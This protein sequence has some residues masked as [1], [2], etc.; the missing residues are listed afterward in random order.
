V[1][2]P[3]PDAPDAGD[4]VLRADLV[5]VVLHRID[6]PLREPFVAAHGTE[7]E[8]RV[9]L[10]EAI[11]GDGVAGWGE[12][13]A[14]TRPTYT[15]EYTDGAFREL[16]DRLVPAVLAGRPAGPDGAPMAWTGV[17]TALTDLRLRSLGRSLARAIGGR[18]TD[19][20][21]TAVIG[22]RGDADDL[23]AVV[24]ARV[25]EG[26]GS[27]KVKIGPGADLDVVGAVRRSFP[28]LTVAA[29]ANGSYRLGDADD[30]ERLD[31][32]DDLGLAYVEQPLAAGSDDDLA[33][34]ARR[35]STPVALDESIGGPD[36]ARRL[37]ATGAPFALNLKPARVGGLDRALGCLA[38]AAGAG[39]PVFVGGMLETGVGRALA[40]A[41][42]SWEACAWPTDLGPSSRYFADDVTDPIELLAGGRLPVPTGP[43]LG[44]TPRPDRLA[45]VTVEQA[46]VR[47]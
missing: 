41:A 42:A 18:R 15:A 2:R 32:L 8:R 17:S 45:A 36:D 35:W 43:G 24:A 7:T 19:V 40:L 25:A 33:G 47:R 9:V 13:S 11:G 39:W 31:A 22:Q 10:V 14:L 1:P 37:A 16:R 4:G 38:V 44:V 30:R 23:R 34:L 12:C 26:Y 27:V 21:A 6:L 3:E 46:V 29:D 20:A 5:E 28:D